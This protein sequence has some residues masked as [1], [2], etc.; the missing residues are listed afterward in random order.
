MISEISLPFQFL[1]PF[2]GLVFDTI[3]TYTIFYLG[4]FIS[5]LIIARQDFQFHGFRREF[6]DQSFALVLPAG[7]AGGKLGFAIEN[8]Y[9]PAKDLS[10]LE[11]LFSPGG[12]VFYGG[13]IFA[14]MALALYFHYRKIPLD[15]GLDLFM[16]ALAFGYA[17]GRLGCYVSGDGC[18]GYHAPFDVPLFTTIAGPRA[19][20][21]TYHVR[22]FNTPFFEASVSLALFFAL[23]I[24]RSSLAQFPGKSVSLFLIING[25][26]RFLVEFLRLNPPLLNILS[27]PRLPDGSLLTLEGAILGPGGGAFFL[28]YYWH[29]FTLSQLIGFFMLISGLI[30]MHRIK[31]RR[32]EK[33]NLRPE[34]R[35]LL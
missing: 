34:T 35:S 15:R 29:G 7:F 3:S 8:S 4:A 19:I 21:P 28:G 5:G 20:L 10:F 23:R 2:T 18:Y 1:D 24:K 11:A 30:L 9:H 26:V 14:L 27:P 6:A 22:V 32:Y 17:V 12:H 16:P 13:M 31:K 25:T 33:Q